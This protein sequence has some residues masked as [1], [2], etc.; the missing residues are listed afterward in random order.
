M[1]DRPG[2]AFNLSV[3][4]WLLGA[5]LVYHRPA[6]WVLAEYPMHHGIHLGADAD[7]L[8]DH[9]AEAGDQIAAGDDLAK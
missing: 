2:H 9:D 1:D 3:G 5:Q 8:N 4:C 6:P 7:G